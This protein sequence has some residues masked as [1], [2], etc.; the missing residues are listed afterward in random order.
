MKK[1]Y[2]LPTLKVVAF[3]TEQGFANSGFR[4]AS[5]TLFTLDLLN[6]EALGEKYTYDDWS[7]SPSSDAGNHFTEDNW[8]NL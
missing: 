7:S 1:Q 6:G 8:G 5:E 4:R 3:R 2:I